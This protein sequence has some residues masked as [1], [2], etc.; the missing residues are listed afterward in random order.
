MV[1]NY[2]T[3]PSAWRTQA[4]VDIPGRRLANAFDAPRVARGGG[5]SMYC[6][7]EARCPGMGAAFGV[8]AEL[9]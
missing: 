1:F 5:R 9:Y 3:G 4:G 8:H 7:V 6:P 2:H